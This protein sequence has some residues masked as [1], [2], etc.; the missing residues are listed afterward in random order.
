M[1]GII[2]SL[3]I[4]IAIGI[5]VTLFLK[6]EKPQ[7]SA[8]L[9]NVIKN[10]A[11][12]ALRTN[13]EEFIKLA[14]ANLQTILETTKNEF[15]KQAIA[16]TLKPLQE[17]IALFDSEAKRIEAE[18]NKQY[19]GINTQIENLLKSTEKL[20]KET[21][22]LVNA[23]KRPEV[24][25]RLGEIT[26]HRIV[27]LSGMS[28]FCSFDEQTSVN[29]EEGRLRPD[30]IVKLP[31]DRHI[32]VDSKA[33]LKFLLDANEA[34]TDDDRQTALANHAKAIREHMKKLAKK[35]YWA[36]FA[37][38]PDYVLMFLP[39]E[40]FF[41]EALKKDFDILEDGIK[42]RVIIVTPA[43]LIALLRTV[44]LGWQEKKL[45]ENA[46]KIAAIGAEVYERLTKF[47]EFFIKVG[48]K[49][50]D[51]KKYYNEAVASFNSRVLPSARKLE[52]LGC[53]QTK[54]D[55]KEPQPL[56]TTA[57]ETAKE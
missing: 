56:E 32:I 22:A 16:E 8:A 21:F 49:I 27:E 14:K 41:Y 19:G 51:V 37:E 2:I 47:A 42:E 36:Q 17:K 20:D 25:G 35:E 44:A 31:N 18:R 24:K 1:I 15:G 6:K 52:D 40:I 33:N 4:G 55:L 54:D 38:S 3:I 53:K 10:L 5:A 30:M 48:A 23:L 50:E 26:L 43:T 45:S 39:G 57:G 12:E 7:D 13:N 9:D 29:T 11:A 28:E 34:A 46:G